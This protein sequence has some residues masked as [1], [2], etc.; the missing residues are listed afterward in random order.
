M[1]KIFFFLKSKPLHAISIKSSDYMERFSHLIRAKQETGNIYKFLCSYGIYT[2]WEVQLYLPT[3]ISMHGNSEH[4]CW[5]KQVLAK[6]V[7]GSQTFYIKFKILHCSNKAVVCF[8]L[9]IIILAETCPSQIIFQRQ[10]NPQV[11]FRDFLFCF[12][13]LGKVTS[14]FGNKVTNKLLKFILKEEI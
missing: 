7:R 9:C 11:I 13:C 2:I 12:V 4:A 10:S 6:N 1:K 5:Q 14:Y 3:N 8:K